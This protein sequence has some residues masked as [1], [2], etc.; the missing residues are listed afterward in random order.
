MDARSAPAEQ[1]LA[2]QRRRGGE[3]GAAVPSTHC[4]PAQGR[5]WAKALL[6]LGLS[7]AAAHAEQLLLQRL[8]ILPLPPLRRHGCRPLHLPTA[9]PTLASCVAHAAPPGPTGTARPSGCGLRRSA[10][11]PP[12][13]ARSVLSAPCR[14]ASRPCAAPP[15]SSRRA[16]YA[17]VPLLSGAAPRPPPP[18]AAAPPPRPRR[19]R[20]LLSPHVP[21]PRATHAAPRRTPRCAAPPCPQVRRPR[22]PPRVANAAQ[23]ARCRS[24]T[25]SG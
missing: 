15:T 6:G 19:A 13:A 21:E 12:P 20:A 17:P 16:R 8:Q 11:P 1:W 18:P 3:A 7:R 9:A 10:V 5:E 2:G 24:A 22:T 14:V 4:Q 25:P 23:T